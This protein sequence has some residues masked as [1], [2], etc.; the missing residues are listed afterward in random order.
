MIVVRDLAVEVVSGGRLTA[1]LPRTPGPMT[2]AALNRLVPNGW[3]TLADGTARLSAAVV[4]TPGTTLDLAGVRTL[5]L[6][7]GP[8]PPEAASLY[9]GSG[10]IT[11]RGVT[12]IVVAGGG[13]LDAT[14]ATFTDLGTAVTDPDSR[15][16][17]QFNPDSGG[18]LERASFLRDTVGLRLVASRDVRLDGVR[19]E[20]SAS[21]GLALQGDVGTTLRG[22]VAERNG[23]N[24]VLVEGET[25]DRPITGISTAGNT[26]YGLAVV[27]QTA[28]RI[29]GV[30]TVGDRTGG[31]RLNRSTRAVVSDFTATDQPIAVFT[32]VGSTGLMFE[33]LH[34]TGGRHGVVVEKST[35]GVELR[36]S[37]ITGPS[38]VGVSIGGH[39]VRLDR[40]SVSGSRTGVRIE[41]GAGG[42]TA[43]GLTL[44]GGDQG[45]VAN[46]GSTRVE[47]TGFVA[48]GIGN[49]AVRTYSPDARISG[50]RISGATTG[51]VT[52]AATTLADTAVTQVRVGVR[53][54]DG[55]A[56]VADRIDVAALTVG[57]DAAPGLPVRLRDSRVHALQAMRGEVQ[58]LGLNNLS[59]P[60]LNLLGAI[61][62]PL[63]LLALVLELIHSVRQRRV[64]S[65]RP[66][67]LPPAVAGAG[68]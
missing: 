45:F 24:G 51:I 56:V 42:I 59:L 41:R 44:S 62:V 32:H 25:S 64:G 61:G 29:S 57:I 11:G 30:T 48:T 68:A 46:P 55:A 1:Q 33:R 49:D 17:V 40:V 16:G 36:E 58:L 3:L 8:T 28:P 67:R 26:G 39:D 22:I 15:A 43:T 60:P 31:L 54:R 14:D 18:S 47:L 9:T 7:G 4:L 10:R 35:A 20:D 37:S 6:A 53:A 65:G 5:R 52:G 66:R 27:G 63:L 50:G 38:V 12:V 2:L 23:G 13:R 34:V 19:V 21:D